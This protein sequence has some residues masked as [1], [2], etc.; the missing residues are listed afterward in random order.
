MFVP[1]NR[2]DR[3]DQKYSPAVNYYLQ[4]HLAEN[5]RSN[6]LLNSRAQLL[7]AQYRYLQPQILMTQYEQQHQP[8]SFWIGQGTK[9]LNAL[10]LPKLNFKFGQAPQPSYFNKYYH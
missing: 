10:P 7:N 3:R 5:Y 2:P 6:L 1:A 9:I 8:Y 4:Q